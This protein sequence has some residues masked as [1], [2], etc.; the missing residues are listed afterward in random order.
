MQPDPT[1]SQLWNDPLQRAQA[2]RDAAQA[3]SAHYGDARDRLACEAGWLYGEVQNLCL[4][5][6]FLKRE[7]ADMREARDALRAAVFCED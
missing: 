2:L 4:E 7:L 5:I 1:R 6:D 3:A